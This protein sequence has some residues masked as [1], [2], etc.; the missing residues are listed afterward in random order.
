MCSIF[1]LSM[2]FVRHKLNKQLETPN[3]ISKETKECLETSDIRAKIRCGLCK[4]YTSNIT[5]N[6]LLCEIRILTLALVFCLLLLNCYQLPTLRN[7][8]YPF[9]YLRIP[10][11]MSHTRYIWLCVF[12]YCNF[13]LFLL[14]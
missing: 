4:I 9:L 6:S 3:F 13:N 8:L 2:L 1:S 10:A 12:C 5:N 7:F 11:C 14:Y